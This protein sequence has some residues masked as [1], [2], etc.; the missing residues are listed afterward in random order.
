MIK[1]L[2]IAVTLVAFSAPSLAQNKDKGDKIIVTQNSDSDADGNKGHG[3]NRLADG[4]KVDDVDNPGAQKKYPL[5]DIND[6]N[7]GNDH[8]SARKNCP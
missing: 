4:T 6:G 7:S 1:H 3:N 8:G 2:I 5:E